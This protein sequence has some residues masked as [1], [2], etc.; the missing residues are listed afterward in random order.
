MK[1]KADKAVSKATREKV[2]EALTELQ[3]CPYGMFR[4]V[5]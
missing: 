1:N 5:L 2:E 3:H 4:L